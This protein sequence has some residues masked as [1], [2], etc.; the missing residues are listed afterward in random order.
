MSASVLFTWELIAYAGGL[1][2][3]RAQLSYI[4]GP[5]LQTRSPVLTLSTHG[6]IEAHRHPRG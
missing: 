5:S 2:C 1:F 6:A 3:Y 4:S